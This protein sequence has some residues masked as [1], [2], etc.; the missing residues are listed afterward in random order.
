M[1][2]NFGTLAF[3]ELRSLVHFDLQPRSQ[4]LTEMHRAPQVP[5]SLRSALGLHDFGARAFSGF[6]HSVSPES[7]ELLS[8]RDIKVRPGP[9][10]QATRRHQHLLRNADA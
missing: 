7:K 3:G 2:Q 1:L 10:L 6:R 5:V 4:S 8:D 9:K